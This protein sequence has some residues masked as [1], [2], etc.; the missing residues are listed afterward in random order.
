MFVA[1]NNTTIGYVQV[2]LEVEQTQPLMGQVRVGNEESATPFAG[3]LE[4]LR[5]LS[6]LLTHNPREFDTAGD[7]KLGE[8]VHH[9]GFD[10]PS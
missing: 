10:S 3:W 5:I 1:P 2:H 7:P 8:E 6:D 4:L 9:V